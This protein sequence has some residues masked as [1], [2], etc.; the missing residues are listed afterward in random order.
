MLNFHPFTR[1]WERV[2]VNNFEPF[3]HR[4]SFMSKWD[5]QEILNID[6]I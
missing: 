3:F 1:I 2:L 5:V 4:I 6:N